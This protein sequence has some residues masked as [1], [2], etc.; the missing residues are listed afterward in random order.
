[1]WK[2]LADTKTEEKRLVPLTDQVTQ[3]LSATPRHVS[4]YMFVTR[5]GRPYD[6]GK[7]SD[8]FK[9]A[10]GKAGLKAIRQLGIYTDTN[11]SNGHVSTQ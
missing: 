6:L 3:L 2:T 1:L 9:E 5:N 8:A 7:I 11:I 4:G 10:C